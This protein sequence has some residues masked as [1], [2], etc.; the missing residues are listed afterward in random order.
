MLQIRIMTMLFLVLS[1]FNL[2][3][4]ERCGTVEHNANLRSQ[5]PKM[6]TIDDFEEF[7]AK[8][9][10]A[11]QLAAQSSFVVGEVY[12]IPVIVH[13]IHD[14]EA[15]GVG[16]NISYDRINDQIVTLQ[17]DFRRNV[18]TDGFNNHPDGADT[19]IEFRLARQMPDGTAFAGGT[20]ICCC[21]W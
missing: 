7:L 16:L 5:N 18:G 19:K 12:I 14:N 13:I 1:V 15:V 11:K 2:S 20:G 21:I 3:A 9:I 6:G 17:N 4:Q 8:E 10:R